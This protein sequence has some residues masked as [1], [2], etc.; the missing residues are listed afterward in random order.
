MKRIKHTLSQKV[1]FSKWYKFIALALFLFFLFCLL[2]KCCK[3]S[4]PGLNANNSSTV[5][6][7]DS[8]NLRTAPN[9][10][11]TRTIYPNRPIAVNPDKILVVPDDPLQRFA[12]TDLINVYLKDTINIQRY[13]I[14]TINDFD[15]N[16]IEPTYFADEYKRIQFLV[17]AE[18]KIQIMERLRL[19][20]LQVKFVTHEWIYKRNS[21][22][23]SDPDY[24][25]S[26][27]YWFYSQIGLFQAW[28]TTRGAD[29]ITIAI[30]DD[31]FDLNHDELKNK[32]TKPWNV[33][34][35]SDEVYADEAKLYHGTHVAGT[36][37]GEAGNN[38]GISGVAPNCRFMPI[39]ISDESGYISMTSIIDGIFYA[40]KNKASVINLSLGY[41]IGN[42][43]HHLSE[44]EQAI[45]RDH[46]LL[47]EQKLWDEVFE[48][49]ERSNTV[50]VQ[51]AGNQRVLAAMDPMK[52]ST[53]SIVVGA[54]DENMNK[55]NFS[56]F[57]NEVTV[58]APGKNIYSSLPNNEMGRLDG[59][60]MS[61]PLVSGSIGL[62]K[63]YKPDMRAE[64]IRK[65]IIRSS[66]NNDKK[67]NIS[68]IFKSL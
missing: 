23:G 4:G 50:I 47:D 41:S 60:S 59:T 28:E 65:A 36:I 7:T 15:N 32:F 11:T 44:E 8:L 43:V 64:D 16:L 17:E 14:E 21:Y 39:Q 55:T 24:S 49:A 66:E 62:I 51:A 22:K 56:N 63:S 31:G 57:G 61:T 18:E 2:F 12:V 38:F 54:L 42:N 40:L 48:I 30:I 3:S 33:M 9:N 37:I 68:E 58:Y 19:D 67:F 25:M 6:P 26:E 1:Y 45:I 53:H 5:S 13:A 29:Q 34:R 35:Y 52:R 27:N 20:T 46:F 10:S